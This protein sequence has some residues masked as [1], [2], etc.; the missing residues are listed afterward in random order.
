MGRYKSCRHTSLA[1]RAIVDL[2][3]SKTLA[4]QSESCIG[5]IPFSGGGWVLV[6]R[7]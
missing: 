2:Q 6:E 7:E 5:W 4:R 3:D 1:G